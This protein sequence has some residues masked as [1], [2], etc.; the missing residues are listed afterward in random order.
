MT[1]TKLIIAALIVPALI[2]TALVVAAAAGVHYLSTR[3]ADT[4]VRVQPLGQQGSKSGGS[5]TPADLHDLTF[6]P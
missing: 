2:L 4:N 5:A 1:S 3:R 6:Q